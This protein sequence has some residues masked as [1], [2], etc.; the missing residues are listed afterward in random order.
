M[1]MKDWGDDDIAYIMDRYFAD[2]SV[3][4]A[5]RQHLY[6]FLVFFVKIVTLFFA[7][8]IDGTAACSILTKNCVR[9]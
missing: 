9:W 3:S 4:N 5:N 7:F 8:K 2:P 1:T 6:T